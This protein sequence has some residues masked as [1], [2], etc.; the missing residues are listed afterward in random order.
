MKRT[1]LAEVIAL[2]LFRNGKNCALLEVLRVIG[3]SERH[4]VVE[5]SSE[6]GQYDDGT[7]PIV[8][9]EYGKEWGKQHLCNAEGE[10]T[11]ATREDE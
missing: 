8:R 2:A 6:K 4:E 9:D 3:D 11:T 1:E 5:K 7:K 10:K